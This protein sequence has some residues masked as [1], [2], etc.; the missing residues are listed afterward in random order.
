MVRFRK[1]WGGFEGFR[2]V[3]CGGSRLWVAVA[4]LGG[5]RALQL[6]RWIRGESRQGGG[7]GY[8][9][10]ALTCDGAYSV[11]GEYRFLGA[12][13]SAAW[14]FELGGHSDFPGPS[15]AMM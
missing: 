5:C 4:S 14:V 7:R 10:A 12:R 2:F 6:W 9:A 13:A 3:F 11:G 8:S 1:V 15:G